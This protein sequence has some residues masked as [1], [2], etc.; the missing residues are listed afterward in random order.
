MIT[1]AELQM[2]WG[3]SMVTIAVTANVLDRQP[4]SQVG[5]GPLVDAPCGQ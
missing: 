5:L 4:Y 3:V 2:N 1:S